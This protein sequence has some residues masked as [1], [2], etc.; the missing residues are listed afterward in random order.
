MKEQLKGELTDV[1]IELEGTKRLEKKFIGI[2]FDDVS[3]HK[4]YGKKDNMNSLN[5]ISEFSINQEEKV[6]KY[7]LPPS[8]LK[9]NAH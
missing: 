2:R 8:N 3:T 5:V 1:E 9:L 7:F 4:K 6:Q